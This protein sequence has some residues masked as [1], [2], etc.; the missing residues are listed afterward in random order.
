M[1][2]EATRKL[3]E[4]FGEYMKDRFVRPQTPKDDRRL[5]EVRT[6]LDEGA[7]ATQFPLLIECCASRCLR[8]V[9]WMVKA[10]ANVNQQGS[11]FWNPTPLMM[12][13]NAPKITRFL[14]KKGADVNTRT[15]QGNTVLHEQLGPLYGHI[16]H[17]ES[18]QLLLEAGADVNARNHD[19]ETPLLRAADRAPLD[20]IELLLDAGSDITAVDNKGRTALDLNTWNK[21]E[22]ILS[23]AWLN[24][25]RHVPINEPD[26]RGRTLLMRAPGSL[27]VVHEY[28]KRGAEP[29]AVDALGMT[30]LMHHARAS[31]DRCEILR[32]LVQDHHVNRQAADAT[33]MTAFL[34][35]VK[36]GYYQHGVK[37][38]EWGCDPHVVDE[39][40]N[41]V[42]H[43]LVEN[44]G[45]RIIFPKLIEAGVELDRQDQHGR[46]PLMKAILHGDLMLV[47]WL[48]K[49]G[50]QRGGYQDNE[51]RSPVD[52]LEAYIAE[53]GKNWTAEFRSQVRGYLDSSP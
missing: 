31:T 11:G 47:E 22:A 13:A 19:G 1:S 37:L 8:A 53:K 48:V 3:R 34:Y 16:A 42:L 23:K 44:N 2:E 29:H 39:A 24:R 32:I 28:L 30:T 15:S 51:G 4:I 7:D 36:E 38:L 27:L 45:W 40:G 20:V 26:E 9:E 12:T 35:A 52:Y 6:L 49:A 18:I 5:D 43:H 17:R 33:G 21:R 50:A 46:T 10:G 41:G 14:L 25:F